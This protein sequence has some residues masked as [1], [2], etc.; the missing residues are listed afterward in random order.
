MP[1][2]GFTILWIAVTYVSCWLL[3]LLDERARFRKK[4]D[5]FTGFT[6]FTGFW[7]IL[8]GLMTIGLILILQVELLPKAY[9]GFL[10]FVGFIQDAIRM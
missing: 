8:L 7:F 9:E 1:P 3:M 10:S 5:G 2:I 4:N 6:G